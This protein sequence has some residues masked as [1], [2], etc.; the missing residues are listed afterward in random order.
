M[1]GRLMSAVFESALATWLKPY[2]V[3]FASFA[4]DDGA[5]IF[6]SL[7]RIAG[8]VGHSER[9]ARRAAHE[10]RRLGILELVTHHHRYQ[11]TQYRFHAGWLPEK[12]STFP[13]VPTGHGCPRRQDMGVRRSVS[14]PSS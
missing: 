9:H 1:S 12:F 3:A 2:A 6:P 11:T 10:L 7:K 14:D 8:M 13:Q 4:D 5:N